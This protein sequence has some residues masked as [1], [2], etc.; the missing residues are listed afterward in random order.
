MSACILFNT[1]FCSVSPQFWN[2][3]FSWTEFMHPAK[4]IRK[5]TSGAI[6]FLENAV[7]SFRPRKVVFGRSTLCLHA[8]LL[9]HVIFS[10]FPGQVIGIR[11]RISWTTA[12]FSVMKTSSLVP[13]GSIWTSWLWHRKTIGTQRPSN[14]KADI[15]IWKSQGKFNYT[16][17]RY[18]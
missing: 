7:S 10:N 15:G 17:C 3:Y 5:Q 8:K 12:I 1:S 14:R 11:P 6:S 13:K 18:I 16:N 4:M 9:F 2:I